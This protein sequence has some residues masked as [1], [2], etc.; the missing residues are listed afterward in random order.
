MQLTPLTQAA[1]KSNKAI[2]TQLD[3]ARTNF[4]SA[5][6]LMQAD[7]PSI[8][9]IRPLIEDAAASLSAA[10]QGAKELTRETNGL[11]QAARNYMRLALQD[12]DHAVK[13][14]K[15]FDS[16]NTSTEFLRAQIKKASL[17]SNSAFRYAS[18]S[19][20]TGSVKSMPG[21]GGISSSTGGAGTSG[22]T[23]VDGQYLNELGEQPRGGGGTSY[24]G[25]DGQS[26]DWNGGSIDR[27]GSDTFYGPDGVGYSGI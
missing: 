25:P 18:D 24:T 6:E 23:W 26:F 14:I 1:I 19:V 17:T 12:A 13:V 22:P 27:G 8:I 3:T 11:R 10:H 9:D 16:G 21:G 2:V 15:N 20:N 7:E 5:L 4:A